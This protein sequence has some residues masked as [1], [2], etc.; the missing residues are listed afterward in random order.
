MIVIVAMVMIVV[1][2]VIVAMVMI[3]VVPVIMGM[4]TIKRGVVTVRAMVP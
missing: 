3:V 1:V 4:I 2:P